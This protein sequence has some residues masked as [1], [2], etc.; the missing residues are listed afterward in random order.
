MP[1]LEFQ[2]ADPWAGWSDRGPAVA[3]EASAFDGHDPWAGW[4]DRGP[5]TAEAK[6]TSALHLA[7]QFPTGFNEALADVLGLP[8]DAIAGAMN[9]A[10]KGLNK[11]AHAAGLTDDKTQ[12]IAENHHPLGGSDSW[13]TALDY[14]GADPRDLPAEP[15]QKEWSVVLGLALQRC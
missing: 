4:S 8:A 14:I 10:I 13:K 11:G 7:R 1:D 6:D 12:V 3:P 9:L 2:Q 15:R 5:G